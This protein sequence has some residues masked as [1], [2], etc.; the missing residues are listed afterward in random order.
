M[1]Y[2]CGMMDA[3]ISD[4]GEKMT[5]MDSAFIITLMVC[6]T[7]DNTRTTKRKGMESTT[8]LMAANTKVGGIKASSTGWEHIQIK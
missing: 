6:A 2:T 7:T 4:F 5:C 8:G 3:S 1:A